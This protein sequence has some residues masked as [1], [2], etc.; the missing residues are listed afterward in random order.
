MEPVVT[1][2]FAILLIWLSYRIS[3]QFDFGLPLWALPS[4]LMLKYL[5]GAVVYFIYTIYYPV[6]SEADIFKYFDDAMV[7]YNYMSQEASSI[8]NIMLHSEVPTEVA[9]RLKSW[10]AGGGYHL[11][12]SSRVMVKLHIVLRLFSFGSYHF[13]SLFFAFLSFLGCVSILKVFRKFSN[14]KMWAVL[15]CLLMPSFQLW[16]SAPLKESIAVWFLMIAI[17]N[18]YEFL[19][20]AN[21]RHFMRSLWVVLPLFAFKPFY[22]ILLV[23]CMATSLMIR[24][25][26]AWKYF[27]MMFSG[28]MLLW[29]SDLVLGS[30]SPLD[31]MAR[32][33]LDFYDHFGDDW[34]GSMT[35]TP[36]LKPNII[37]FFELL[38][39]AFL[40]AFLKPLPWESLNPFYLASAIENVIIFTM[41][42]LLVIKLKNVD[43]LADK[44][45]VV[46]V[47]CFMLVVLL[48]LG[49]SCPIIGSL[50]RFKSP[51]LILPPL[52]FLLVHSFFRTEKTR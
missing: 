46:F 35:T 38:P 33:Q 24:K 31:L 14:V 49:F 12:D 32:K 5:L 25:P 19:H 37:G 50:M 42:L 7:L 2:F 1:A 29:F 3:L 28:V 9:P 23:P 30:M 11:F 34:A 47:L 22:A 45:F 16:S 13:H 52:A 15:A 20:T 26:H 39:H 48:M 8:S 21:Y 40:N 27:V 17:S 36:I 41:M 44:R 18:L 51:I 43:S 4:L 6:R 10:Y